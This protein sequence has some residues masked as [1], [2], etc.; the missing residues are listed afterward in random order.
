MLSLCCSP[1]RGFSLIEMA[2]TLMV[3][4]LLLGAVMVPLQ[5]QAEL[6]GVDETQRLLEQA[7]EA[8][9][10]YA[11][12]YGYFPCPADAASAGFEPIAGVNHATG[13]C[14]SY[15]GFLPA[16]LLGVTPVDAQG[17]AL[18]AWGSAGANRIRYAVTNQTVGGITNAFTRSGGMGSAGVASLGAANNLLY[19]CGSGNAV[20]AGTN[21]GLAQTLAS[22]AVVVIWSVGPNAATTG[23][24]SVHEAENPNPNGGSADRIFVSR[25]WSNASTNEFDD[26]LNWIPAF[27]V[28]SRLVATGQLP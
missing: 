24:A 26:I 1:A 7:R 28:V 13:A 17:F 4:A 18:D 15:Y 11:T 12:S 25:V 20:T 14:P 21:C 16:A 27:L 19:I 3:V 5:R 23:G 8:L 9:L 22:N 6:H 2:V 10:G